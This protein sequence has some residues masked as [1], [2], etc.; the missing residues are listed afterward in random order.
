MLKLILLGILAG[1][2]FST[3]F[4]LNE[5]MSAE[6][7]H[8]FWSASLRYMFMITFLIIFVY[9]QGK[10]KL[11]F[12]T[13]VLYKQYYKFWILSGSIGFGLFYAL[14]CFSADFAPG[15]VIAASWQFTV[16]ASLFIFMIFGKRFSLAIWLFSLII[17]LGVCL[18]NISHVTHFNFQTL[19]YGGLPVL[20]AAFCYPLGNQLVWEAKNGNHKRVPKINSLLLN[21][22]LIKVLLLSLGSLPLWIILAIFINPSL[23]SMSQVYNTSLVALFSGVFATSIFLY[24]RNKASNTSELAGVDATQA[25]EVVFALIGGILFL[26][27]GLPN[28]TSF[29]GLILIVFGLLMFVKYS[30]Q[31]S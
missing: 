3:T 10:K 24:A 14:I 6:G 25:S 7:G 30:K 13:F 5:F 15:W 9:F 23:P 28:L 20:I 12:E 11:L 21:N 31:V 19:L 1:A 2:F 22:P 17:F 4:V 29:I 18:V 27:T 8:W 16:V 26:N